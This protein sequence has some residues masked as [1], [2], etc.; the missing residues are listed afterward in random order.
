M[1][2]R[3]GD[4]SPTTLAGAPSGR[5]LIAGEP[6]IGDGSVVHSVDPTTG[7]ALEPGYPAASPV[8]IERACQ[9]AARAAV[10]YRASTPH[11]RARF[12]ERI[13]E[14]L[15][16]RREQLIS[17]A[18]AEAALG[19]QRLRGEAERTSGQLRLFA[20]ELRIGSWA[21]V[22]VDP[23][24]PARVPLPR[25]DV[26]QRRIGIGPVAVFGASNFPL[27]F[28]T[29]GGDTASALAAGCPVVAK[30][31]PAHLGT[32]EIVAEAITA[33][34]G[35]TGMPAGVFSQ[36]VGADNQAGALLVSD[37]RIRAVG[38]TG[39]RQGGLALAAIAQQRP[40]PIP[41]YA[42][43]SSVN[44]VIVLPAALATRGAQLGE[45]F[46]ASLTLGAGQFC[47]NPG[48][49]LA[50]DGPGLGEFIE[51]AANA[52]TRD[53]GATMLTTA[54][55]EAYR[56]AADRA[57]GLAEVDVLARG[58][59]PATAAGAAAQ[60]LRADADT[61]LDNPLLRE[62]VFGASSTVVVCT[63]VEQIVAVLSA[64]DGQ[65][66]ATVHSDA[67]DHAAARSLLPVLEDLAGRIIFNGWPT[68]V[69]VGHA[70][71]HGGPYPATTDSRSTSV[72]SAAIDRFLRPVAYQDV[73]HALLPAQL[74]TPESYGYP[75]RLDGRLQTP[76]RPRED[77]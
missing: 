30:A 51:S 20:D 55:A 5:M 52:L 66:T 9:N 38:F 71:V 7:A 13:A 56:A 8:Q 49:I 43:M 2:V 3:V 44:P 31:H 76:A 59:Q 53:Q 75:W 73:P 47:T 36:I 48:L 57:A 63:D 50:I 25:P 4:D 62:E 28:S 68:G 14:E 67:A 15:D 22:R 46:A 10:P 54:I 77:R 1:T 18:H 60:L 29:A 58:G 45:Q 65:L 33:A 41:V 42:E 61:F 70:M 23:A 69:E 34:A 24:Q 17:Q 27:A 64:M 35:D 16:R 21:Q 37:P 6:I 26:R 72:G 39:S 40:T 11:E 74:S 19:L 32:A 12:L